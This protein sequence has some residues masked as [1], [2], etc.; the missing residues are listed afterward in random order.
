MSECSI[1]G[2]GRELEPIPPACGHPVVVRPA[3]QEVGVCQGCG[4][5]V[6]GPEPPPPDLVRVKA[7][8][9]TAFEPAERTVALT[10]LCDR[11]RA[12]LE[13]L[14]WLAPPEREEDE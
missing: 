8:P 2:C 12:E 6:G 14:G 5:A 9:A 13:A 11:H 3:G 4:A 7:T 10:H 1:P